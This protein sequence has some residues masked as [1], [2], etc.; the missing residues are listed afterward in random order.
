MRNYLG[1]ISLWVY[2]RR[3]VMIVN[4][5]EMSQPTVGNMIPK[6]GGPELYKQGKS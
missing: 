6:A 2:L 3:V 4:C 5:C 1:Q